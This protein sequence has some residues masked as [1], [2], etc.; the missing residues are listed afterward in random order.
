MRA[1]ILAAGLGRRFGAATAEL[2]KCLLEVGGQTLI[3]RSLDNLA[4]CGIEETIIVTG[5]QAERI[6]SGNVAELYQIDLTK[7][8]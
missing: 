3:Q 2:P 8:Q 7:L 5:H 1:I 4:A 6:L